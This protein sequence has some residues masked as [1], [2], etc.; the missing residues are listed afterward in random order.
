MT[1]AVIKACRGQG[2]ETPRAFYISALN[3]D[4]GPDSY[5]H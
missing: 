5:N 1:H 4:E 2:C 3:E